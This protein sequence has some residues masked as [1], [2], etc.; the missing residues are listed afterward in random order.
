MPHCMQC[1]IS[2]VDEV[3]AMCMFASA[4][5]ELKIAIIQAKLQIMHENYPA[6]KFSTSF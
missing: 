2:T 4:V 1:H 5:N 3:S 6:F